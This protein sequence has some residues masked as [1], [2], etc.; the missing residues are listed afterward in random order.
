MAHDPALVNG[1]SN[2]V[3][4]EASL[5]AYF[6]VDGSTGAVLKNV[7]DPTHDGNILNLL[8][9][10]RNGN[11]NLA[12]GNQALSLNTPN[13]EY[14]EGY[15]LGTNG[16]GFAQN[17]WHQHAHR[18]VARHGALSAGGRRRERHD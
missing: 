3:M 11:T 15:G 2:A 6:L 5:K 17:V 1:Y 16:H 12:A 10:F 18:A 4:A 7:K 14:T 8:F 13:L 9:A